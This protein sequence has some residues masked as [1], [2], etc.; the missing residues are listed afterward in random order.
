MVNFS[1]HSEMIHKSS[2]CSCHCSGWVTTSVLILLLFNCRIDTI[3]FN[4]PT[5][6]VMAVCLPNYSLIET[7]LI[8]RLSF[9]I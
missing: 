1:V 7:T 4:I 6:I 9:F 8:Y 3:N 5:S 2:I